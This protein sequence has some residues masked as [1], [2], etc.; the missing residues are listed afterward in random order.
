MSPSAED[1][2]TAATGAPRSKGRPGFSRAGD[3]ARRAMLYL[4]DRPR[5]TLAAAGALV[6]AAAALAAFVGRSTRAPADP[7]RVRRDDLAVTVD[8]EGELAAVRAT[9]IG[10]PA[11]K[12]VWDFKIS[13]L[14]PE[15]KQVRKGEPLLGFDTQQLQRSLEQK[16]AEFAE[17]SK[18]IERKEVDLSIQLRDL[19]LRLDEAEARLGKTRLKSDIPAELR[20]DIEA[21]QAMLDLE[22]SEKEVANLR[23]KIEATR[24][25]GE[26]DLRALGSK[27]DRAKGRVDELRESIDMMTVRAPQDGIVIYKADWDEKK[28]VGDSTWL[29]E[30]LLELP[31]LSEMK[32]NGQVDEADAGRISTGQKVTIR[33]EAR[34]DLDFRGTVRSIGRAVLRRSRRASG[35]VYKIEISLEKTDPVAMRP[36]MRFRGEIETGRWPKLLVAPREAVFLRAAGPVVWAKRSMRWVEVPIAIGRSNKSLVEV[37]SGLS[38][39]DLLSTID[40]RPPESPRASGPMSAGL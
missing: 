35:K 9:D 23:A 40:L 1:P 13:F 19:Q 3:A 39:G 26:A 18:E 27:R 14:A 10:P 29:G 24:A 21:R 33:L 20:A 28:K 11:I 34:P 15:S 30:K 6:L 16:T 25:A 31:D 5:R 38:E 7:V 2:G 8:V 17:A 36:A 37:V 12:N 32:A 4:R 22:D